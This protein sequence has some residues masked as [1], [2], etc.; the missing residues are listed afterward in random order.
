MASDQHFYFKYFP[1]NTLV[2]KIF[3]KLPGLCRWVNIIFK[4]LYMLYDANEF[5]CLTRFP[6]PAL[7]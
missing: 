3:S 7:I 5:E 1:E 4:Y 2:S 6:L